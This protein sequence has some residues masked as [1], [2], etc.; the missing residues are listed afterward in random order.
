MTDKYNQKPRGAKPNLV[1]NDW[2]V[3]LGAFVDFMSD[4][5][6]RRELTPREWQQCQG[7][8]TGLRYLAPKPNLDGIWK[9]VDRQKRGDLNLRRASQ[10]RLIQAFVEFNA[11]RDA[12]WKTRAVE[13]GYWKKREETKKKADPEGYRARAR[14]RK[15]AQRARKK[16]EAAAA[17]LALDVSLDSYA[18]AA[19]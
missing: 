7:L 11:I 14:E 1:S 15:Q 12:R 10:R 16:A 19:E 17:D 5:E 13:T 3:Q 2:N 9:F 6:G 18:V 4:L 8:Y